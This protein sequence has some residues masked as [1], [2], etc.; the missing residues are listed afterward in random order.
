MLVV[1]KYGGTS[2]GSIERIKNVARKLARFYQEGHQLVVVVSAMAGETDRLINLAYQMTNNP[3]PRELDVLLATGEQSSAALLAMALKDMGY[4]ATSLVAFQARIFTDDA[5]GRARIDEIDCARLKKELETGNIVI[6]A[7]FQGIDRHGDITTLGRGGSDTTA[8]ALA[9]ALKADICEIYTDV[10]GVFTADPRICSDAKK[11]NKISYDEMMELASLGA[12]VL[13]IRSV[14]VAKKY[15]VPVHVRSSFIEQEG[16][17]VVDTDAEMEKVIVTAVTYNKDE[18]RITVRG[19]PDRPGIAAQLFKP[20][21]E[22]GIVVDMIIQN[23]SEEGITDM[24]FTVPKI[25]FKKALEIARQAANKIGAERVLGDEHIGKVS[26]VGVGMR[27]H[28]GVAARMFQSL[29]NAG[30]NILMISTSE[31][32]V[33]CV[34]DEKEVERAVQVLHKAFDLGENA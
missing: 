9:A 3:D 34:I 31:I 5:F 33:S 6:V 26:I 22:A 1:Q 17:M 19:V 8:V 24:T 30:I 14:D 20:I 13:Q 25:D 23:T 27:N 10:E 28:P 29:A 15:K 12:K 11:I 18:A 21:G 2:V 32:K 16:T 7:G 4:P